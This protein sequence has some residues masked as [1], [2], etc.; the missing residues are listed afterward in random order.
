MYEAETAPIVIKTDPLPEEKIPHTS[1]H[2]AD[3]IVGKQKYTGYFLRTETNCFFIAEL[4]T[5]TF[6][7]NEPVKIS[8]PTWDKET[9]VNFD[10]F[11][12]GDRIEVEILQI[13]DTEPRDMPVYSVVLVEEGTIDNISNEVIE[14]LQRLGY[15]IVE[16]Q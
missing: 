14:Y 12:N 9:T 6:Y 3:E 8:P 10:S 11:K 4:E 7:K 15:T 16:E 2:P 13:G 1:P 5:E